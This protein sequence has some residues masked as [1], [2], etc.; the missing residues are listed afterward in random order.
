MIA[1]SSRWLCSAR[2][3][4]LNS[5]CCW[6]HSSHGAFFGL[7][8][9]GA[10][11]HEQSFPTRNILKH[12]VSTQT[13]SVSCHNHINSYLINY[14]DYAVYS[15]KLGLKHLVLARFILWFLWPQK[16]FTRGAS[17]IPGPSGGC[18]NKGKLHKWCLQ[19]RYAPR[20]ERAGVLSCWQDGKVLVKFGHIWSFW[21]VLVGSG[22]SVSFLVSL[23]WV[24]F[25]CLTHLGIE[26]ENG[27]VT[28]LGA[29]CV[30]TCDHR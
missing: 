13:S 4:Q 5:H 24:F 12:G 21:L 22:W 9:Q 3:I 15:S 1:M 11:W 30:C 28:G 10:G 14:A 6:N 20:C 2:Q 17:C 18:R 25:R 7:H 29:Q 16:S 27:V 26:H 19:L 8:F 23:L